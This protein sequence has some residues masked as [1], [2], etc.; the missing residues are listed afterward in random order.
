[1][2]NPLNA[3]NE[4]SVGITS[5]TAQFQEGIGGAEDA[6][7]SFK[8]AI[9]AAGTALAGLSAGA[10]ASSIQQFTRFEDQMIQI[11]KV[12]GEGVARGLKD[13]IQTLNEA[14]PTTQTQL[15][16]IA[17]VAGRLG[18]EG[19]S[20]IKRFTKVVAQ[21]SEAT[22]IASKNAAEGFARIA[23]LTKEPISNI[24][25]L[26]DVVNR[27]SNNMGASASEIVDSMTRASGTLT[28]LGLTTEEIAGVTA[29]VNEVSSSSRLAGTQLRRLGQEVQ[30]LSDGDAETL[31]DALGMNVEQFE[32]LAEENPNELL[33]ELSETMEEGGEQADTLRE[34]FSTTSRQVLTKLGSNLKQV[35][36]AQDS[37]NRE[38]ESGSSLVEEYQ[39]STESTASQFEIFKSR[40][41]SVQTAIGETLSPAIDTV[42]G[43]FNSLLKRVCSFR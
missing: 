5:D 21:L 11:E 16:G 19:R 33:L 4:V 9:G 17:E 18:I 1:M 37:A 23:T 27:L 15:T 7:L 30:G 34:V 26:G 12:V 42:L 24:R 22:N 32:K 35:K 40:I 28:S 36:R 20:S 10:L 14:M 38:M 25:S 29:A 41:Q 39:K 13:D 3:D 2:Q 31:A 6:L 8:G 43:G